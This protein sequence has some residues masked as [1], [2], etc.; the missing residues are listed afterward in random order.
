[1]EGLDTRLD[2]APLVSAFEL[3]EESPRFE[4]Q[5]DLDAQSWWD[6]PCWRGRIGPIVPN[7]TTL[8]SPQDLHEQDPDDVDWLDDCFGVL[9]PES[10]ETVKRRAFSELHDMHVS[11]RFEAPP[12][13]ETVSSLEQVSAKTVDGGAKGERRRGSTKCGTTRP[14]SGSGFGEVSGARPQRPPSSAE[15]VGVHR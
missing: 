13:K 2:I 7:F 9:G 15:Q 1:M 12:M 4:E 14:G 3:G 6:A 8:R 5:A 10:Q 11:E